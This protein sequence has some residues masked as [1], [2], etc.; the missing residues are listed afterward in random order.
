MRYGILLLTAVTLSAF[1]ACKPPARDCERFQEGA[2][3]FSAT[4]DGVERTTT[5]SRS[6]NLEVSEYMGSR[7]SASIRWIN[8]CEYVV[9]N[10][11][12]RTKAEEKPIHMKIL[13]TSDNSYTFE[14]KMV[15][16]SNSSRGTAYKIQ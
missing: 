5:F 4:I 11:N 7:D 10:L 3:R 12:P 6:G 2:F 15:G 16:S 14:Y 13:S 8:P 9:T 1:N